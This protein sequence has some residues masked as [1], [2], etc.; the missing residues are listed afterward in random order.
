MPVEDVNRVSQSV[1]FSL[2]VL[3]T[4]NIVFPQNIYIYLVGKKEIQ[5]LSVIIHYAERFICKIVDAAHLG[6][7]VSP[8]GWFLGQTAAF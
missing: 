4:S 6:K 1:D 3:Q 2:P 5:L 7:I 8:F